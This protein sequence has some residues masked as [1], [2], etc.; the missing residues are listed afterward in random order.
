MSSHVTTMRAHSPASYSLSLM[1]HG[2]IAAAILIAAYL[3]NDVRKKSADIFEVVAGPGDNWAATVAPARG[4]P[5]ASEAPAAVIFTRPAAT[6]QPPPVIET[7]PEPV[8]PAPPIA[9]DALVVPPTTKTKQQTKKTDAKQTTAQKQPVSPTTS[10]DEF[11]K[12]HGA[13][14]QNMPSSKT[15]VKTANVTTNPGKPITPKTIT[16]P[17]KGLLTG[18]DGGSGSVPGAGGRALTV[19]EQNQLDRYLA[20]LAEEIKRAHEKPEGVSM[21][22]VTRVEYYVNADGTIGAVKIIKSSG[23]RAFD[24][25]VLKAFRSVRSIGDRP[26]G[27]G[28]AIT[29]NFR[30]KE[31]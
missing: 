26:D 23:N 1:I 28:S 8:T 31:E 14:N 19:A 24:E 11:Q 4:E 18:V 15:P 10:F 17:G 3:F 9:R 2:A 6:P 22:L 16:S 30:M 7:P 27:R 21:E 12:Q 5:D 25:S 20:A 29:A 13:K